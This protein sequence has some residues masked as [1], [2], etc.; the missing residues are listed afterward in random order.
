[1]VTCCAT[2]YVFNN[3]EGHIFKFEIVLQ[4]AAGKNIL[5]FFV[6]RRIYY[7]EGNVL[8]PDFSFIDSIS[9]LPREKDKP[10]QHFKYI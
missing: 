8:L 4:L 5:N 9:S 6:I 2:F 3:K 7:Y 1:M 10:K